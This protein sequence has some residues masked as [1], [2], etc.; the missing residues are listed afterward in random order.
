MHDELVCCLMSRQID[1]LVM[2]LCLLGVAEL[3]GAGMAYLILQAAPHV[4]GKAA[5]PAGRLS[6]ACGDALLSPSRL[7]SNG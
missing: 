7:A 6:K 5:V 3:L 4:G 1:M 2:L